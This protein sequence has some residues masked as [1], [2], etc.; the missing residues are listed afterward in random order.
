MNARLLVIRNSSSGALQYQGF[1]VF[2]LRLDVQ[3]YMSAFRPGSA[4]RGNH[5]CHYHRLN[6]LLFL[7]LFAMAVMAGLSPG[8]SRPTPLK[9]TFQKLYAWSIY[10]G[11]YRCSTICSVMRQLKSQDC[12]RSLLQVSG[13]ASGSVTHTVL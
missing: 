9:N 1:R 12:M 8:C 5:N 4:A 3:K 7:L 11:T 2:H 6:N 13:C 10:D